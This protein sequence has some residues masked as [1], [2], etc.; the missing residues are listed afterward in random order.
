MPDDPP[1]GMTIMEAGKR[2]GVRFDTLLFWLSEMGCITLEHG[3]LYPRCLAAGVAAGIVQPQVEER[4][5]S[6]GHMFNVEVGVLLTEAGLAA[7]R[8]TYRAPPKPP[9]RA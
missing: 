3:D 8:A 5:L 2:L 7:V 6:A 1:P 9:K 4:A